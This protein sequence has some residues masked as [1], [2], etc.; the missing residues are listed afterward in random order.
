MKEFLKLKSSEEFIKLLKTFKPLS[1]EI[2]SIDNAAGR[3]LAEDL[4]S[5]EDIPPFNRSSMDGYAVKAKDTFG[6]SETEAIPFDLKGEV[7]MGYEIDFPPLQTGEAIRI[8]TGGELPPGSDAVVMEEYTRKIDKKTIEIFKPVAPFENVVTQ[9]EDIKKELCVFH[10]G[11]R[12]NPYDT[13]IL[14]GL[15]LCNIA[16]TKK[17]KVAKKNSGDEIVTKEEKNIKRGKIRDVN[18]KTLSNL[19]I[20]FQCEPIQMGIVPD[21]F[22]EIKK[23]SMKSIEMGTDVVMVSGG[24]SIGMRDL[25]VKVF[26]SIKG[27]EIL[28]HGIEI[29]PGKPTILGRIGNI[30]LVGLPG[31]ITSAIVVFQVFIRI[32]LSVLSG[33]CNPDEDFI[34]KIY[35]KLTRNIPSVTGREDYVRVTLQKS[36][37]INH[38]NN[39]KYFLPLAT[40]VFGKSGTIKSLIQ[41]NGL[42]KL[43]RNSEGAYEGEIKEVVFIA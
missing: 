42:I 24:S 31:H 18:T 11:R 17:P 27:S 22:D 5:S 14:A 7:L 23:L 36:E 3:I 32:L 37:K 38:N 41:S 19:L 20:N 30:A 2:I 15:G 43:E 34:K 12:L 16:V 28:A 4:Y 10:S 25:T 29:R 26:E 39:E 35:A 9:G 6:V 40:P 1:S 13:G 8:W 33:S 21:D